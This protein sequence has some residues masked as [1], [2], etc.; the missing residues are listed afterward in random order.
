MPHHRKLAAREI[1]W[2]RVERL[3]RASF[4]GSQP[5]DDDLEY[6]RRAAEADPE[7][8]SKIGERVRAEYRDSLRWKQ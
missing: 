5:S 7:H 3:R 4:H 2:L 1:D 8:Y 6:C